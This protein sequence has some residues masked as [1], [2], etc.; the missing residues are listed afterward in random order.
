[1]PRISIEIAGRLSAEYFASMFHASWSADLIKALFSTE[2]MPTTYATK[3]C[4][5]LFGQTY[6]G[7]Q[8]R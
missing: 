7:L 3:P 6:V 1:M 5:C 4:I 2:M 8:L